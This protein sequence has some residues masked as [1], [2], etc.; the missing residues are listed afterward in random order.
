[1]HPQPEQQSIL[2][3][4]P[5]GAQLHLAFAGELDGI[6]EQVRDHL[7]EAQRIDQHRAIKRR[8][9]R[10]AQRQPLGS[11][12]SFKYPHHRSQQLMQVGR[13]LG[14]G[15]V[16]GFDPCDIQNIADQ[17]QHAARCHRRHLQRIAIG[18]TL[19]GAFERQLDHADHRVHR[20]PDL[21]AHSGQ[22]RRLGA[23]GGVG[24]V[25]GFL[26][27]AQQAVAFTHIHPAS[28]HAHDLLVAVAVRQ[29]PMVNR[30]NFAPRHPEDSVMNLRL[31]PRHQLQVV[32][33]VRLGL[34]RVAGVGFHHGL[35]DHVFQLETEYVEVGIVAGHQPPLA[36]AHVNRVR[37]AVDQHAHK[38]HLIAQRA[39]G[40]GAL[41][42]QAAQVKGPAQGN[43]QQH[44]G[45]TEALDDC[46]AM[47]QPVA[48]FN[49]DL[50]APMIGQLIQLF[51]RDTQQ[52]L[53]EDRI[54]L[55]L[56]TVD[57][58]RDPR[59]LR[60]DGAGHTQAVTV[61]TRDHIA[62]TDERNHGR[63]GPTI[64]HQ[65][66][67][68]LRVRA[69][70]KLDAGIIPRDLLTQAVA[71]NERQAFSGQVFQGHQP[72][73][74][75]AN[76]QHIGAGQ[77]RPGEAQLLGPLDAGG[78][79]RQHVRLAS[80]DLVNLSRQRTA[81]HHIELQARA[82]ADPRQHLGAQPFE[83]PLLIE[84]RQRHELV[85]HRHFHTWVFLQPTL[86]T[87]TQ[88]QPFRFH[89]TAAASTP[90]PQ[91]IHLLVERHGGQR[92]VDDVTQANI[93]LGER[94]PERVDLQA[95][96]ICHTHVIEVVLVD[97]V[98]GADGIPQV[99][100]G[101]AERHRTDGFEGRGK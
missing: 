88:A 75:G 19:L 84:K 67:G 13:F 34:R 6:A 12:E 10:H 97:Q 57:A 51:R 101:P 94:E 70:D 81:L 43:Q 79:H 78:N 64:G 96:K 35:A 55:Q 77:V 22:E 29:H 18:P 33:M 31:A 21:V 52:R 5:L 49:D 9:E 28:N 65:L 63:I 66:H 68:R 30:E 89:V 42:N 40:L 95:G 8:I 72:L 27:L 76:H 38:A 45:E 99:D 26:Q 17:F 2:C 15:Q 41:A 92:C 86:L 74:F 50:A 7:L 4:V 80:I 93:I 53:V 82:Q 39:F 16:P 59:R 47:A 14:Q 24:I 90:A 48:V 36:I 20:R 1:M 98:P 100:I 37:R 91:N 87:V 56:A 73:V 62:R 54:Q 23:V 44:R 60:A 85:E 58:K 69:V 25:L 71:A 32:V 61:M 83:L 46:V 11:R 3:N